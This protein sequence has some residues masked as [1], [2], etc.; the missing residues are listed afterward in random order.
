MDTKGNPEDSIETPNESRAYRITIDFKK[1]P[2]R[3]VRG[4]FDK[5]GLPNDWPEFVE[6][7]LSFISFYEQGELVNPVIYDKIKRRN[8]DFIFCSVT[9]EKNGKDYYCLANDDAY[10]VGDYV[11][12]PSAIDGQ[13]KTV[14]IVKIEYFPE[15][16]VPY[17]VSKM[18]HIISKCQKYEFEDH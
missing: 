1:G 7:I 5:N 10:E 11:F 9:F 6:G 16:D 8:G 13:M 12:V 3:I 2:Q 14:K 15:E 17:P 4:S 18:K